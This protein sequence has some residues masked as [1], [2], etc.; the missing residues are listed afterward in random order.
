[1]L[2]CPDRQAWHRL[3]VEVE[4]AFGWSGP[5]MLGAAVAHGLI[6]DHELLGRLLTPSRLLDLSMRRSLSPPQLRFFRNGTE[7]HPNEYISHGTTRR[8]QCF[9]MLNMRSVAAHLEAGCTLVLDAVETFDP[10]LEVACRALQWWAHE[11]VQVNAYLTTGLTSGFALHWDDHDVLVVQLAGEKT[12]GVRG[13]SRLSPMY[14]DAEHDPAPSERVVWAGRLRPGEVLHVPRGH[15]HQATRVGLD[16]GF[17]LHLTFG[18]VKRTGVDWVSWLADE[19]RRDEVFRR[20]LDRHPPDGRRPGDAGDMAGMI[21]E[22]AARRPP[23]AF[24]DARER[25]RPPH[26]HVATRGVFGPPA[27]VVCITEFPPHLEQYAETVELWAAGKKI[28][29]SARAVPGLR[30]LLSGRPVHL[31]EVPEAARADLATVAAVLV[32]EEICAELTPE[33]SSGYTGLVTSGD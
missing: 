9:P 14:R 2:A 12:W 21:A 5:R 26:R 10:V 15:W 29:F 11:L 27:A 16:P 25:E 33:L 32:R 19:A 13:T 24:L 4:K 22:L 6:A 7:L 18:F 3:V 23:A 20:D 17:S 28:T 8:G 30:L 1:L 31:D